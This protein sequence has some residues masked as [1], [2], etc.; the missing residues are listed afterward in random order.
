MY[1]FKM[2]FRFWRENLS[3]EINQS[4]LE[5]I[6]VIDKMIKSSSTLVICYQ[7]FVSFQERI[8]NLYTDNFRLQSH[9]R[10]KSVDSQSGRKCSLLLRLF[11]KNESVFERKKSLNIQICCCFF[12]YANINIEILVSGYKKVE[13]PVYL[14]HLGLKSRQTCLSVFSFPIMPIDKHNLE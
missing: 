10:I 5:N 2:V 8:N 7:V 9:Q 14:K 11:G 1:V 12:I 6:A 3:E 13:K 4:N